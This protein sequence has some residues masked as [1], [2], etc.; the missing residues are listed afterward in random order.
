MLTVYCDDSGTSPEQRTA[1]AA[2]YLA[3]DKQWERFSPR[4]QSLLAKYG[5]SRMHRADLE[6]FVRE[7]KGW[8]GDRRTE[9]IKKAHAI[10]RKH[11]YIALGTGVIKSDYEEVMPRW[12][13]NLFGGVY[14]WCVNECRVHVGKWC[15]KRR[16]PYNGTINWVFEA[17]TV[18]HGQVEE[19]LRNLSRHPEWGQRLRIGEWSF[20]DKNTVPLQSADII[21]YEVFKQ[22][23]NQIIDQGKRDVR[24]SIRHLV[25]RQDEPY[26]KY[27]D[28]ARLERW[29]QSF[30]AKG[31]KELVSASAR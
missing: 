28:K 13:K 26:L 10:I 19:M 7:F 30:E 11:I 4:W 20:K 5:I 6:S 31:G 23:E 3:S 16:N 21:A 22:I 15:E 14:V 27:W 9:L 12:V 18:G 2:G 25:R 1:V 17:G 8:N 29:V 24:L